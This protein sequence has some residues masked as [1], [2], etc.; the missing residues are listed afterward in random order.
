MCSKVLVIYILFF[1]I[2]SIISYYKV[3]N[4]IHCAPEERLALNKEYKTMTNFA[5]NLEVPVIPFS[6]YCDT[7]V[8]NS[9]I[10]MGSSKVATCI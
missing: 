6:V 4:I 5:M 7:A 8:H 9:R 10:N 3:L 1:Q 2:I